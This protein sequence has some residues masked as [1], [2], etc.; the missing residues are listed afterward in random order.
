MTFPWVEHY[1]PKVPAEIGAVSGTLSQ[2]LLDAAAKSPKSPALAFFGRTISYGDLAG[3]AAR[4]SRAFQNLG[5]APGERL[6]FL[7]PNCPLVLQ[8][9][10]APSSST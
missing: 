2:L 6:A 9:I 3:Q 1:D 5:V 8:S 7:L 10:P 4:L